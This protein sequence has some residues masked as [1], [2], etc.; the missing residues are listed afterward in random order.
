VSRE[1]VVRAG[2]LGKT[3]DG[4][5]LRRRKQPPAVRC[6]SGVVGNRQPGGHAPLYRAPVI[7]RARRSV[8]SQQDYGQH[9][10]DQHDQQD[11]R[12]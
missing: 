5:E 8:V 6:P 7:T 10:D 12:H 11:G 4:Q 1:R 2:L 9:D 3:G